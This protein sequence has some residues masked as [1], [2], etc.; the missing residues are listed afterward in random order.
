[1]T[2]RRGFLGAMLAAAVAPA[3][4]RAQSLMP[5]QAPK[6]VTVDAIARI[7][8]EILRGELGRVDGF[9][10]IEQRWIPSN[11][12]GT[13]KLRRF[14]PFVQPDG[15]VSVAA[16]NAAWDRM[17]REEAECAANPMVVVVNQSWADDLRA[18]G[19]LVDKSR[20]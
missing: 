14:N 12:G 8:A 11:T 9:R 19:V 10:F 18:A 15:F 1:M 7:K 4:V 2:T 20:Q 16:L 6:I 5:I 13:I 17:R 3:I